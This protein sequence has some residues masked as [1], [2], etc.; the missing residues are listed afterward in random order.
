MRDAPELMIKDAWVFACVMILAV[1]PLVHT[2]FDQGHDITSSQEWLYG[3]ISLLA[4]PGGLLFGIAACES[5]L[6]CGGRYNLAD[7]FGYWLIVTLAGYAQWFWIVPRLFK[8]KEIT[9]L[10]IAHLRA[11]RALPF[12]A[13]GRTPL[14][15]IIEDEP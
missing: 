9:S 11:R 14:E 15:K 8:E 12:D 3:G 6:V 5:L 4:F 13:E 10:G 1:F 2:H 7:A